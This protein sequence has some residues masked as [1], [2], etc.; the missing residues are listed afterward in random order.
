VCLEHRI[1]DDTTRAGCRPPPRARAIALKHDIVF[2]VRTKAGAKECSA[3]GGNGVRPVLSFA[4]HAAVNA[5]CREQAG[6]AAAVRNG[7]IKGR[8]H[9]HVPPHRV[10]LSAST[11]KQ[12]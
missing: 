3:I 12:Y 11:S 9:V 8:L 2:A 4:P 1:T 5:G 7:Q 10:T 6:N